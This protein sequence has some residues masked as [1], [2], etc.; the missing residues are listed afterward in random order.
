MTRNFEL[1]AYA[2]A[3]SGYVRH[4]ISYVISLGPLNPLAMIIAIINPPDGGTCAGIVVYAI[5]SEPKISHVYYQNC[6]RENKT[7][8]YVHKSAWVA[9]FSKH[10]PF[11]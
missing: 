2:M 7:K 5:V 4:Y 11:L 9:H 6:A 10:R 8:R 3:F 1:L